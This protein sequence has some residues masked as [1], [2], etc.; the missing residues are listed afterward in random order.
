[1]NDERPIE[2]LLRGYAKKRRADAGAPGELHP[3]TRRLLQGEV[4]RQFRQEAPGGVPASFAR[5][6]KGWWPRLAWAVPLLVLVAVGLWRLLD[7]PETQQL[8]LGPKPGQTT[9][10]KAAESS[11]KPRSEPKV[12]AAPEPA[13]RGKPERADVGSVAAPSIAANSAPADSRTMKVMRPAAAPVPVRSLNQPSEPA[14]AYGGGPERRLGA[15]ASSVESKKDS[16]RDAFN[17]IASADKLEIAPSAAPSPGLVA[18]GQKL[19]ESQPQSFATNRVN[20]VSV[21]SAA[22][23]AATRQTTPS[24]VGAYAAKAS[25]SPSNGLADETAQ[26]YSQSFANLAPEAL[27]QKTAKAVVAP[28]VAPVLANFRVEQTGRHLRVVDGDGSTYLGE[29]DASPTVWAGGSAGQKDPAVQYFQS[30]GEL[31]QLPAAA[32]S[33]SPQGLPRNLYRVSGTNR[34]LNQNVVFT[35]SMVELTNA[36]VVAQSGRSDSALNQTTKKLA[37]QFPVPM[38]NSFISGRAQ[39][40]TGKEIE[41]NAVP[42]SP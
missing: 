33:T 30:D 23:S 6:L 10:Q 19:E 5:L 17:E 7:Q 13:S 9:L 20:P 31:T 14:L 37:T 18:G 21:D 2:K 24:R 11:A 3:A 22:E 16:A 25:G 34:T 26:T 12:V 39:F 36:P 29:T 8:A 4:A 27:K 35:W 32:A 38:Q 40:G 28:P 1:M 15:L 42:V 41:I